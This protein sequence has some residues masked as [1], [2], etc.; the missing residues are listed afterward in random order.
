MSKPGRSCILGTRPGVPA[1][2]PVAQGEFRHSVREWRTVTPPHA[3]G[4]EAW[5]SLLP[6]R[7]QRCDH[8]RP[9][10]AHIFVY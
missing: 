1:W 3:A 6:G 9:Y 10:R 8:V 4:C 5:T 7:G 2:R